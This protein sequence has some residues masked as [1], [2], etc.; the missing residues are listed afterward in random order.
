M[1]Q[2]RDVAGW[3]CLLTLAGC[4]SEVAAPPAQEAPTAMEKP[5]ADAKRVAV[6]KN[7]TLEIAAG[8][9]RVFVEGYI[10]LRMGQ[11]EQFMTRKRTKE[12]EAIVAADV[13]A[14][15]IHL[16][17]L[18]AGAEPGRTVKFFPKYEPAKGPVIRV[19]VQY[20]KDGKKVTLPAQQWI[21]NVRTEKDMQEDWVFAG[22]R[23]IPDPLDKKKEPFYA[24][25]DGDVICLSN[26]ETAMLDL[27][28]NSSSQNDSLFFEAHTERI[29]AVGTAVTVI[30]EPVLGKKKK[31]E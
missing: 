9:R 28:I 1:K 13:D 29:P 24:A 31:E 11:M 19:S 6:G 21:R 16:A 12:H 26:F 3:L 5:A 17:L 20:E 7:V 25:N 23:L 27:P 22:S 18:A 15:Q 2:R 30:L 14:R 10:C 8:R 4:S